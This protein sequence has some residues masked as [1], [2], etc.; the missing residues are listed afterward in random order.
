MKQTI[1]I[2]DSIPEKM[3]TIARTEGL[4]NE[5]MSGH[6]KIGAFVDGKL[7]GFACAIHLAD[8]LMGTALFVEKNTEDKD[9][10]LN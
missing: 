6:I 10:Q 3:A 7:V 1:K 8:K 9:L 4:T 2:I 5:A